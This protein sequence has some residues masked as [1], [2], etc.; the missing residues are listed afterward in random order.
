MKFQEYITNIYELDKDIEFRRI[1]EVGLSRV[2]N[3][4]K[5]NVEFGII[6]AF[7]KFDNNGKKI[8]LKENQKRN[9]Q[10]LKDLRSI[11][12]NQKA[13]GSFRFIGHWKECSVRIP[14]DGKL[15]ECESLGGEISNA[16]EETWCI[17][18]DQ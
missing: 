16:L 12:G 1:E 14:E 10:L 8:E 13:Y 4:L 2:Y 9:N 18:N 17:L 5:G 3:R 6:S 7:R 15:S 11:L